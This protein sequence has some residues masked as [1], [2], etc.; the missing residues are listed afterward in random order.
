MH[1]NSPPERERRRYTRHK[2]KKA[3]FVA[4]RPHFDKIGKI[5]NLGRGGL[6]VEY[7]TYKADDETEAFA[8][9]DIFSDET[10]FY[11]SRV[12]CRVVYDCKL[13]DYRSFMGFATRFCGLQFLNLSERQLRQL[14]VFFL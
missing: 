11:L 7:R 10:E 8:E 12:P 2:V 5:M 1:W 4:F 13:R 3:V 6:C 9:V 14:K